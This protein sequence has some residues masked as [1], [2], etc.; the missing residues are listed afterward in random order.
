M[1][2]E[3]LRALGGRSPGNDCFMGASPHPT[4]LRQHLRRGPVVLTGWYRAFVSFMAEGPLGT[5]AMPQGR[6]RRTGSTGPLFRASQ[7]S[8]RFWAQQDSLRDLGG[9]SGGGDFEMQRP[10]HV[11][12]GEDVQMTWVDWLDVKQPCDQLASLTRPGH[13]DGLYKLRFVSEP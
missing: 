2:A 9:V 1:T 13:T 5:D 10:V 3:S 12:R 11:F 8:G 7:M 4:V 6:T